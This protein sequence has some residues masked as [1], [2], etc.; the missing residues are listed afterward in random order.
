MLS[1]I[2]LLWP[3]CP[4]LL[5]LNATVLY[6]TFRSGEALALLHG[7][8]DTRA[9][10]IRAACLMRLNDPDWRE[11]LMEVLKRNDD[12][13]AVKCAHRLFEVSGE[14]LPA[15]TSDSMSKSIQELI[16]FQ[17]VKA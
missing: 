10:I 7:H 1:A 16:F 17:G 14:S 8:G 9:L 12:E 4:E 15:L 13:I 3:D 5:E 2:R 6:M 11:P